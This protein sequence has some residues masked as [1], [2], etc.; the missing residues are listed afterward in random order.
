MSSHTLPL[1]TAAL[2]LSLAACSP[3]T[4][5]ADPLQGNAAVDPAADDTM[6]P[7]TGATDGALQPEAPA[8]DDPCDA[9]AVQPLIG[10]Q[11][12]ESVVEQARID[13]DA[14][15]VRTLGPDEIVTM[16]YRAGRLNVDVDDDGTITGL[17]CG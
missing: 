11:A 10:E 14:E 16:E 7:P 9:G 12:T 1:I 6:P 5:P 4:E 8:M 17:R 2:A 15:I 13:A 3:P